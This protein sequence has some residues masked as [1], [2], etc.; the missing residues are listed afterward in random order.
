MPNMPPISGLANVLYIDLTNETTKVVER[1]DLFDK[2]LGGTGVATMLMH[3]EFKEGTDALAPESPIILSIGPLSG[4]FPI[5]T[6]VVA[7]FR[8]P[9]T[10]EFGE[11]H[12]GG[13]LAM[14]MRFAGYSSI[15][16]TGRAKKPVYLSIY[17]D[18][19]AFKDASSIWGL[20]STTDI[21]KIL[22]NV[23]PSAGKRSIIRIGPAGENLIRYANV[24]VD[25][26][27][28]FGRLGLGAVFGSK[29]L[30]AIV[31]SGDGEIEVS[32]KKAYSKIYK[33]IFTNIVE[34]DIMEKYHNLGTTENILPLNELSGL[35]T[36][37][38]QQTFFEY[39]ESI[40]GENFADNYLIR[41]IA[42]AHCP[43][44]CI[45][46]AM[47][48]TSFGPSHEYEIKNISYD[49]ELV[50]ALGTNLGVLT[51]EGVLELIDRCEQY[52][53]D[54]ISM[55]VVLGWATEMSM[56]KRF[57]MEDTKGV[58]L[59]WG[60]VKDYLRAI[61]LVVESSNE[62][63]SALA[64]GVVFASKKYGG[65]NFAIHAGGLEIPGY[66][67]GVGNI[68][69]LTVGVRHSHLDNGGYS[70]DQ[71]A[72]RDDLSD[73][74]IVDKL[75]FEDDIRGVLT[76]L[77]I[78]LFARGIYTY[79]VIIEALATIGI[80]RTEKE[81]V[82]L[83]RDIF[84]KKYELKQKFGFDLDDVTFPSRFFETASTNGMI[85]EARVQNVL[86]IYKKK[87]W[88]TERT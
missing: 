14:A 25:T 74:N 7:M 22:R 17:N 2:Y 70:V 9:L 81:L 30:K 56:Q 48:K 32:D 78:C 63:Y 77:V 19:I 16:I 75:I 55:G 45:H 61:D 28:H 62:F 42:C 40:S 39:A 35:P 76:S 21:G 46:I 23:E 87:R 88:G 44:G 71:K 60:D 12:A 54:I 66:H 5:C 50:Y 64:K 3:E 52:G 86:S 20:S 83:G 67:T 18:K 82:E 65:E 58:S 73:E 69:G 31:I 47:L 11:S 85:D 53:V 10:G 49:Y 24:N 79:D 36:R 51:P 38:L 41:K 57:N 4:I 26:Y 72:F 59:K 8:S 15:V 43:I 34:T 13:R 33:E 6:K 37:N 84:I 29:N 27:R 1:Q 68:V 80:E